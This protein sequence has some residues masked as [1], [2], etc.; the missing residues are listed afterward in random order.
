MKPRSPEQTWALIRACRYA[1]EYNLGLCSGERVV[2]VSDASTTAIGSAFEAAA[3]QVKTEVERCEIPVPRRNGEE[4]PAAVAAK[5]AGADVVVMPLGA[6]LSWTRARSD[7][8]RAGVRLASMPSITEAI[9]LRMFGIDYGP[10]R[11]RANGLCDLLDEGNEVRICTSLGTD[12][13]LSIAGR[14]GHGRKGGLYR[15]PGEWGNLPCGE[16]FIAP[17]EGT[18][19]GVYV[20][21]ASHGGVGQ[22]ETPI[23]VTV[24]DGRVA[25]IEGGG[26]ASYLDSLLD[27]VGDPQA[28]NIAEFGIGC[29]HGVSLGGVTLEDEKMLGTCHI[30]VGSNAFFG[31]T[32]SV[33]IHLDGVLRSPSIW[34]DDARILDHGRLEKVPFPA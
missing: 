20:V 4:P 13:R 33:P 8:T 34:I 30:A 17:V 19:R 25:K 1:L 27:S 26:S 11:E 5:M 16:A 23:R 9:V 15:Q 18:A 31:G 6:S 29:N 3:R 2:V 21:D 28:Y 10:V 14:A 22:V 32:V 7:A 12:L 24:R